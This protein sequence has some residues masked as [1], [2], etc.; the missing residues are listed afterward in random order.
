MHIKMNLL[1]CEVFFYALQ[2]AVSYSPSLNIIIY[3][4]M[5]S[6]KKYKFMTKINIL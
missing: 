2:S 4:Y 1:F 5:G 6:I 3:K